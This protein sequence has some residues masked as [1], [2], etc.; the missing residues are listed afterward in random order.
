MHCSTIPSPQLIWVVQVSDHLWRD[1][2]L[3]K[4]ERQCVVHLNWHWKNINSIFVNFV[5]ETAMD[6]SDTITQGTKLFFN[7]F[8]YIPSMQ[9]CWIWFSWYCM[10]IFNTNNII[11]HLGQYGKII[12]PI[13][14]NWISLTRVWQWI[15]TYDKR[16][17]HWAINLSCFL[18]GQSCAIY[19]YKKHCLLG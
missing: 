6:I 13:Q 3:I 16:V 5:K 7:R 17:T 1:N 8:I 18:T 11:R 15:I 10:V 9:L 14:Y 12:F 4:K 19:P 2:D